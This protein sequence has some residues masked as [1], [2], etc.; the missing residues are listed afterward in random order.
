MN[1]LH[2]ACEAVVT[3]IEGTTG[4]I[5]F[6]KEIL[7]PYADRHL[8]KYVRAH[9]SDPLTS[10]ALKETA[11]I[12]HLSP[13]DDDALIAQLHEW[14]AQDRKETALKTLQ[15]AIWAAGYGDGSLRGH[16]YDD[17]V[18]ALWSW[19][20]GGIKIYVYSSGSVAAQKLLFAHSIA[21]DLT[22]AFSGYFDTTSG[23]KRQPESYLGI[24]GEIGLNPGRIL[25]LSDTHQ[26]LDA[27]RQAGFR[28]VQVVRAADGTAE[29]PGHVYVHSFNELALQAANQPGEESLA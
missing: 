29:A 25:F 14:I 9:R 6:V 24:A 28:T 11:E 15:G 21:G 10:E 16:V 17:A 27:A 12:A 7:F 3:D 20:E 19:H 8:E 22:P 5:A 13:D 2:F 26:E 23:G 18:D 1:R 4:S